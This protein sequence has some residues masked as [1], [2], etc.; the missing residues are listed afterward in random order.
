MQREN[1]S[2]YRMGA[3]PLIAQWASVGDLDVSVSDEAKPIPG[4]LVVV[5]GGE[6][7]LQSQVTER[8]RKAVFNDMPYG[9]YTLKVTGQ[10]STS[11][12]VVRTCSVSAE[13]DSTSVSVSFKDAQL[14]LNTQVVGSAPV[15]ADGLEE[16]VSQACL[17][18]TSRCV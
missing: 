3:V 15:V 5:K 17:L 4:E 7:S 11:I 18:Y 10:N 8:M 16:V 1:F 14:R 2:P 13:G 12:D 6:K 9:V